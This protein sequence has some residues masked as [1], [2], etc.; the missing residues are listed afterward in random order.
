MNLAT[1]RRIGRPD[2]QAS[3]EL[4][5]H[6]VR[7]ASALF[8]EQGYSA[9]SL[10]QIAAAAGSGK[11]T[12]Y[13]RFGSKEDLFAAVITEKSR[14]L[15]ERVEAAETAHADPLEALKE[16]CRLYM[17]FMLSPDTISLQR[18]MIAEIGRFPDLATMV[19]SECMDAFR[20]LLKRQLAAAAEAGRMVVKDVE[21]THTVLIS[22]FTGNP[23]KQA[24]FG[25]SA[26]PGAKGR[27]EYFQAAWALFI[28]GVE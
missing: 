13:R 19:L 10:E 12:L 2:Q 26:F 11:Q 5:R 14:D 28:K 24:L 8:V 18:V 20:V 22:L 1:A 27:D 25:Q 23:V 6:I 17:D 16:T 4:V 9:T 21:L 15:I 7:T 3:E